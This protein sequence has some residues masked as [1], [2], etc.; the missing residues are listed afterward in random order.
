M[1]QPPDLAHDTIL[2]ALSAHFGITATAL[3]F[4]PR[5]EDSWAWVYRAETADASAYLL[6]V[7]RGTL[8]EPALA[9]PRYLQDQGLSHIV[10]PLTSTAGTLWVAVGEFALMVYPFIAGRSA[11]EAG[12]SEPQWVEYGAVL[13]QIHATALPS[14]LLELARRETYVPK[15]TQLIRDLDAHIGMRSFVDPLEQA[16]V[17]VWRTRRAQIHRL[18]DRAEA[19]GLRLRQR[20]LPPVLC[21]ADIHTAN[22]LL[23]AAGQLWIV[24]WDEAMLA[25]KER[26]LMFV[27]GGIGSEWVNP[28]QTA[29]FFRGYGRAAVDPLALAYYRYDWAVQDIA[30]FAARVLLRPELG[31]ESKRSALGWFMK[32]FDPGGMIDLAEASRS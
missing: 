11:F 27:V 26:D 25:P 1:L 22:V 3:E 7:R 20:P 15:A 8:N 18:A 23:D 17:A 32:Q 5:G 31:A 28:R 13:R 12:M 2:A 14:D 9:I 29:W 6:K 19:L 30:E 4:I 21:H 16:L 10:A 24:D